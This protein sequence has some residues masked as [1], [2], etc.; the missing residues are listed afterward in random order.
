MSDHQ[1][2]VVVRLAQP[3]DVD[4][5]VACS[6][7]LFAEDAGTRDPGVNVGWSREFGSERFAAGMDDASR[8][9]PVADCGGRIV[10]HLA[11]SVAEGSAMR[12][13]KVATLVSMYV[14]PDHRRGGLG[15]RLVTRFASWAR[16][17]GADLAE[18]TAYAGNA[19]AI[20]FCERS[21]FMS[22]SV[23]LRTS[24]SG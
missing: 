12:P 21:G 3:A 7:A 13:V 22:Q 6:S 5:L 17:E 4:G 1:H 23:T 10:G 24:L 14:Q 2:E 20:R 19:D 15:K 9:L 11:G 8:V 16:E 18:V